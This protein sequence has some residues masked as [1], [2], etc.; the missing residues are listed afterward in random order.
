[1]IT[2]SREIAAL[3]GLGLAAATVAGCAAS[4]S[5]HAST[6]DLA[7]RY[8]AI[9]TPANRVLDTSFDA[10]EDADDDLSA[11]SVLLQTIVSTERG[12]DRELLDLKLPSKMG[13]TAIEL[14][15][16]NEARADLTA[17][18]ASATS[19]ARLRHLEPE[20]D[21][22]NAPVEAQ[23]RVLRKALGLPPPDTD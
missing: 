3:L 18:A 14:V 1:M 7:K 8:L 4:S 11:A 17:Q 22:M 5:N 23:V 12:F 13:A 21:A 2:R 10:L 19:L 20:L 15:R 6:A 9:A 16:V